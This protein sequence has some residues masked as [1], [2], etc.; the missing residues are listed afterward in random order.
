[1]TRRPTRPHRPEPTWRPVRCRACG[2]AGQVQQD[3]DDC[4]WC[5]ERG[6][7][8]SRVPGPGETL[9]GEEDRQ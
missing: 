7:L 9:P 5:R 3:G 2:V 1:M 6:S 4:P 8:V